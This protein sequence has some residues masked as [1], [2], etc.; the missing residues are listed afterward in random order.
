MTAVLKS[1][2]FPSLTDPARQH[3]AW[4][5]NRA[6]AYDPNGCG[7]GDKE[8][9]AIHSRGARHIPALN[10][11]RTQI[12]I[13]VDLCQVRRIGDTVSTTSAEVALP[14]GHADLDRVQLRQLIAELQ[15][16]DTLWEL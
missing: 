3:P 15:L 9:A 16:I 7:C 11:N 1:L 4:C 14:G 5:E 6:G 2:D 13:A 10:N 12:E 8:Y